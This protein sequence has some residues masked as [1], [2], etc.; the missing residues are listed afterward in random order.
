MSAPT[1]THYKAP[2][3]LQYF[4]SSPG[5]GPDTFQ[6][7]ASLLV[8]LKVQ[9]TVQWLVP[10]Q[11]LSTVPWPQLPVSCNGSLIWLR[12]LHVPCVHQAV[13]HCDNQSSLHIA[14]NPV[15]HERRKHLGIDCH[16][17]S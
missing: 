8:I 11:K 2:T 12:D 15:F 6:V 4:K 5:T 10:L 16:I 7:Y 14:A 3:R 17:S 9:E 1:V 13:L